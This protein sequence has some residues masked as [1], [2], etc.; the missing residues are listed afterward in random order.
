[1]ENTVKGINAKVLGV[2]IRHS[3]VSTRL[4]Q[5]KGFALSIN[6][7]KSYTGFRINGE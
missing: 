3:K 5:R 6:V 7:V 2:E 1:M 4:I